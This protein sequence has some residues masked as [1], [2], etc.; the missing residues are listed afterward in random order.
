MSV[1]S[2]SD[3]DKILYGSMSADSSLDFDKISTYDPHIDLVEK[4]SIYGTTLRARV[5]LFKQSIVVYF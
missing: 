4:I 5:E 2:S 1:D 3:L